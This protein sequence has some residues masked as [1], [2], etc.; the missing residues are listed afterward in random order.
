MILLPVLEASCW[1][2]AVLA[3]DWPVEE[4]EAIAAAAAAAARAGEEPPKGRAFVCGLCAVSAKH[5][6]T[7]N[8][9][10]QS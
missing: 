7:Q 1:P 5:Y 8:K 2:S 6:T 4:D 9:D 3:T 10:N